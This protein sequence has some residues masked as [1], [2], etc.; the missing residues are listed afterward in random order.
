MLQRSTVL[1]PLVD[2]APDVRHPCSGQTMREHLALLTEPL[3]GVAPYP[4]GLES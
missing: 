3:R 1:V 2:I 4:P